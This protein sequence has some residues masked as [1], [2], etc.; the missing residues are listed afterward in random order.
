[1][2]ITAVLAALAFAALSAGCASTTRIEASD[3][4]T[5]TPSARVSLNLS[6]LQK[7]PSE[8]QPGHAIEASYSRVKGKDD[9]TVDSGNAPIVLGSTTFAAPVQIRNSFD[10]E[11]A[12]VAWRYRMQSRNKKFLFEFRAGAG[13][14]GLDLTIASSAQQVSQHFSSA[15]ATGGV[16]LIV[17]FR[18]TTALQLRATGYLSP[19]DS[20]NEMFALE[21]QV[22]QA[23][24]DNVIVRAGIV[25]W[26]I[27]GQALTAQSD[28]RLRAFGPA[29]SLELTFGK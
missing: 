16:G 8:P 13:F 10:F 12:D 4:S 19:A 18:S 28:F 1:V 6:T 23:L 9:Q 22:V 3:N 5:F 25:W 11:F 20:V 29:L 2:R 24:H 7:S 15:G 21:G 17:P 26:E 27:R 14:A